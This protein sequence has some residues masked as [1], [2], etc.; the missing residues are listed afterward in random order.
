MALLPSMNI[1][2]KLDTQHP[3]IISP[4]FLKVTIPLIYLSMR[5]FLRYKILYKGVGLHLTLNSLP[6]LCPYSDFLS[7]FLLFFSIPL[8]RLIPYIPNFLVHQ[9]PCKFFYSCF[10]HVPI[11]SISTALLCPYLSYFFPYMST[12]YLSY[13]CSF[14]CPY[15]LVFSLVF[16]YYY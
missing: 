11:F 2:A 13:T 6:S 14:Y 1:F 7:L 16:P 5:A 3:L 15:L 10:H 4:Y 12:I 8:S 9:P